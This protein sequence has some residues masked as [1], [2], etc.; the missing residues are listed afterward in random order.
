MDDETL[1]ERSFPAGR[2]QIFVDV[3]ENDIG[4]YC[5]IKERGGA[6]TNSILLPSESIVKLRDALNEA[7][8]TL[9]LE[10]GNGKAKGGAKA[11]RAEPERAAANPRV[12]H[13]GNLSWDT[14]SESLRALFAGYGSIV[15]AEV[16]AT[17]EGRSKGWALVEYAQANECE[18]ALAQCDGTELDGREIKVSKDKGKVSRAPKE[19]RAPRAPREPRVDDADKTVEPTKVFV[20]NL[21][22]DTT[23]E[24]LSAHCA[25]AGEVASVE[26]LTRGKNAR[27][28]GS[29]IVEYAHDECASKA[30]ESLEGSE[31]DGRDLRVRVYYSN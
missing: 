9:G 7:I 21:S 3:K 27:P 20:M 11:A 25:S 23:E 10:S 26:L 12:V 19:P 31:L 30:I 17:R 6:Q 1:F 18:Y 22:F 28:S 8:A 13:V 16:A 14:T 15:S 5:K 4:P 29:A 24:A 2:K